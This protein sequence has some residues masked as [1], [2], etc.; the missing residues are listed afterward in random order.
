MHQVKVE[1]YE[2]PFDLLLQLIEQNKLDITKV[3]LSQITEEYIKVLNNKTNSI[4]PYELADFLVIAAKLLLIKSKAL[5]PYLVWDDEDDGQDLESQLKM[6]KEYLEA[7]KNIQKI[8]HAKKF[9]YYR[10]KFWVL[11]DVGFQPP[12]GVQKERLAEIFR[13]II[14]GLKPFIDLPKSII[15]KTVNIQEKIRRIQ[16]LIFKEAHVSFHKILTDAKDKT[17][18][19][20]TFLAVLELMKQRE[21][22]VRQDQIFEDIILERIESEF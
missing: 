19:I 8:I 16:D 1:H 12:Q 22:I 11:S 13:G 7:S 18:V 2:G 10:E 3:S 17:E 6:Y 20:V 5:M 21:I 9:A 4:P 15:R 14:Q